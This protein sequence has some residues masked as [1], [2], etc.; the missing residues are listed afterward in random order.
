MTPVV[1]D[2][3]GGLIT[4]PQQ[5]RMRVQKNGGLDF[6]RVHVGEQRGDHTGS[7]PRRL[8]VLRGREQRHPLT[9]R[10][11]FLNDI[12]QHVIP[13][14][15]VDQH[16]GVH[17]GPAQRVGDVPYDRVQGHGGEGDGPRPGRVLVR[18][19]DR[20][21]GEEVHRMGVGDLPRDRT[22]DQRVGRQRQERT[23]LLETPDGK[24]RDLP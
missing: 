15:P 17:T 20:H 7:H 18:A 23:V 11:G 2:M 24:D 21:R 4:G 8:P 9:A 13:A 19:G 14:V 12:A 1:R 5:F 16:Q 6:P 3:I 22:G 10:G